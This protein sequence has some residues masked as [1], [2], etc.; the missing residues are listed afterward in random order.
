MATSK[1]PHTHCFPG[2]Q[3]SLTKY[4]EAL[5]THLI[6]HQHGAFH[7][8]GNTV[9]ITKPHLHLHWLSALASVSFKIFPN[10]T[11]G[12]VKR[13]LSAPCQVWVCYW[14][15]GFEIFFSPQEWGWGHLN[16]DGKKNKMKVGV[17]S[18]G[19]KGGSFEFQMPTV[20]RQE[21]QWRWG[22]WSIRT[23]MYTESHSI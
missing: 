16:K 21:F 22:A 2:C 12:G 14:T 6:P 8:A 19:R 18:S 11:E 23:H 13:V 15:S 20:Q 3:T 1:A 10:G 17:F 4:T 7:L 5:K 9:P